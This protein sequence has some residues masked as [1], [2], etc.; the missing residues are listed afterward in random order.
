MHQPLV[1]LE[2]DE[3]LFGVA[4]SHAPSAETESNSKQ[5]EAGDQKRGN[6]VSR[7]GKFTG[8]TGGR[9]LTAFLRSGT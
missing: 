3:P 2:G 8:A 1:P 9:G 7:E 5:E 4:G 6:W